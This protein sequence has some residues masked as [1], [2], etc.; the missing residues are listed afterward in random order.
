MHHKFAEICMVQLN[1]NLAHACR[2]MHVLVCLTHAKLQK[3]VCVHTVECNF[4]LYT[5]ASEHM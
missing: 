3:L 1:L 4:G 2:H 5:W